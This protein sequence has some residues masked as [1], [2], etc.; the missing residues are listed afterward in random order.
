MVNYHSISV[1]SITC[2]MLEHVMCIHIR[3]H[4]DKHNIQGPENHKLKAKHSIKSQLLFSTHNILKFCD[5][6]RQLNAAILDFSDPRRLA[7][8]CTDDY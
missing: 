5:T 1:T 8:C 7:L 4:L 2:K 6:G 3:H